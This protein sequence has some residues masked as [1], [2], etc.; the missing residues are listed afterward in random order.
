MVLMFLTLVMAS[1]SGVM[2][3]CYTD[4][5]DRQTEFALLGTLGF[6]RRQINLVAW[7]NL[8]LIVVF[9]ILLGTWAGSQIG[10]NIVPVLE[11]AEEGNRVVPPM[12]IQIDWMI[13]AGTLSYTHLTLP[14]KA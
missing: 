11:I 10:A 8:L 14:T 1:A 13:L 9:G 3:F 6:T 5:R 2:L 4:K 7:F 12:V